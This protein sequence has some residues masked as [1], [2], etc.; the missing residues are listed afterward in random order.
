MCLKI[1]DKYKLKSLA[2]PSG[3]LSILKCSFR[4]SCSENFVVKLN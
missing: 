1:K 3:D 4:C 2:N